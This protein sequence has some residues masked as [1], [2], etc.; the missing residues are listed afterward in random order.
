[1]RAV[2][3]VPLLLATL[4]ACSGD[5]DVEADD[6]PGDTDTTDPPPA[7]GKLR[8]TILHTNDWQ[9]HMLGWSPNHEYTPDV[10]GDDGTVG[11]LARTA[12]LVNGIRDASSW[13]VVL[14]DGGDWMAGDLFQL[15]GESHAAELQV[16]QAMRYDAITLGNHE[17]DWGPDTLGRIVT[18]GDENGVAVP[19]VASNTVTDP[20]DPADDGLEAH[21][22]SG[23]IQATYRMTLDNGLT[24]GLFGIVGDSAASVAPAAA[25]TTFLAAID[26]SAAVV[27]T[28]ADVDLVI[29]ITHNGV[30]DDPATSPDDL[31]ASAVPGIDVIV[32]GHSHTPLF[33]HRTANG[34]VIVQAGSHTQYLGQLDLAFDGTTWEVEAY[35]LHE[36]DDT[37]PGDPAITALVDSFVAALEDGPLQEMGYGF[38]EPIASLPGDLTYRECEESTIGDYVTDAYKYAAN[39]RIGDD[40]IDV[41]F[42]TQGVIREGLLH[43]A[44]GVQGFSDLFRVLPLGGPI[45]GIPGYPLVHFYVTAAELADAC[46]VTAS[47]TPFYGC[48]YFVEQSGLRCTLDLVNPPFTRVELVEIQE[49]ETYVP[50]D[51]SAA[52]TELYHVAVD[53]YVASLMYTLEDLSSGLVAITPKD[54]S[55]T[56]YADLDDAIFD[57]DPLTVAV[58]EVKLWQALV[59]YSASFPDTTGDDLPDVPERY[60][61]PDGRILGFTP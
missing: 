45:D 9:S 59:E 60:L 30:T 18:Q 37:I 20:A 43:G 16:M 57:G 26:A 52:N 10:T 53:S 48:N 55:G 58:E 24:L 36:L 4:A 61:D 49:G 38:D 14:L 11:G 5:K 54:A 6:S 17:F 41:A 44:S 23:R 8:V 42:E 1:M 50:L 40:P 15:L 56:P 2:R 3:L 46:E 29:G 21:F 35:T 33:E 13:P 22:A 39:Q 25:P 28:L 19:I 47:V 12:T 51:I 27:P 7:D 34:T 31:L 32:G